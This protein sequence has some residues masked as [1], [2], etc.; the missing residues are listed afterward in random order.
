MIGDPPPVSPL[1]FMDLDLF[2]HFTEEKQGEHSISVSLYHGENYDMHL[3]LAAAELLCYI[4]D[5]LT[6]YQNAR[7]WSCS[8][9]SLQVFFYFS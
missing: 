6:T 1:L 8:M 9:R 2:S 7:G 3:H 4:F 5:L